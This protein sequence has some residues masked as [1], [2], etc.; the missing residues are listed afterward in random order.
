MKQ[1]VS[2]KVSY[3]KINHYWQN[4]LGTY[5]MDGLGFPASAGQFV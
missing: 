2:N 1:Q 4:A 3:T 5:M